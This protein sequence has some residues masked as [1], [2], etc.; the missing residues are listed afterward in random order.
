MRPSSPEQPGGPQGLLVRLAQQQRAQGPQVQPY[1]PPRFAPESA[2]AVAPGRL[3]S[4]PFAVP[5]LEVQ[6]E[7]EQTAD[8]EPVPTPRDP[9]AIRRRATD[10]S[11]AE[12]RGQSEI[13]KTSDVPISKQVLIFSNDSRPA[14]AVEPAMPSVSPV[15]RDRQQAAATPSLGGDEPPLNR[16]PAATARPAAAARPARPAAGPAR[17]L[18][19][20]AVPASPPLESHFREEP[21]AEQAASSPRPLAAPRWVAPDR[22][23]PLGDTDQDRPTPARKTSPPLAL[24]SGERRLPASVERSPVADDHPA[25]TAL[26]PA[27]EPLGLPIG[28]VSPVAASGTADVP[29]G[30]KVGAPA[31][32]AL[33]STSGMA[34]AL[35]R[36]GLAEVAGP[37]PAQVH[38]RIGRIEIRSAAPVAS[39]A[40]PAARAPQH[41]TPTLSLNEYLRRPLGGLQRGE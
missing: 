25:P 1:R 21:P 2:A 27:G 26:R 38:I 19:V 4:P 34:A 3:L 24:A 23:P 12:Q 8:A 22:Q 41:P 15:A 14:T 30:S 28:G 9:V 6:L 17:D 32:A 29:A 18:P 20:R 36:A 40:A 5:Q 31:I 11:P 7:V 33:A 10:P 37:A 39:P 13:S 16:Q 35:G